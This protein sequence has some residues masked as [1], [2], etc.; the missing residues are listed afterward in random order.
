MLVTTAPTALF[1][2]MT[3]SRAVRSRV[4]SAALPGG[5]VETVRAGALDGGEF[6]HLAH[7]QEFWRI[8][9]TREPPRPHLVLLQREDR[10][11]LGKEVVGHRGFHVDAQRGAN[12]SVD[13]LLNR[14][15]T[16]P[17]QR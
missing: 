10:A 2:G 5:G 13:R 12:A 7:G 17:H 15:I 14:R 16:V 11:H 8:L 1:I 6:E 3:L 4:M 9:V